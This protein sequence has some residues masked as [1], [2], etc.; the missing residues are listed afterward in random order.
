MAQISKINP[1]S[2]RWSMRFEQRYGM[3]CTLGTHL[4]GSFR[5]YIPE[6]RRVFISKDVKFLEKLYRS[7]TITF[8]IGEASDERNLETP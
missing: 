5:A 1:Q 2:T 3:A 6:L 7:Q 8:D 4:G